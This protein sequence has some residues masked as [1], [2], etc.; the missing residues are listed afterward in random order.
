MFSTNTWIKIVI[1]MQINAI[2]FGIG[3]VIVLTIPALAADAKIWLPVVVGVSFLLSPFIASILA[4]RLR[5]RHWKA[6]GN[7]GDVIS[8]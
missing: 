8:G 1:G 2:L 4:P 7:R 6:V 3:A 5:L